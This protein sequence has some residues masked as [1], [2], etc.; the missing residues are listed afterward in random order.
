MS[1]IRCS[2]PPPRNTVSRRHALPRMTAMARGSSL[3]SRTVYARAP[4]RP[5]RPDL[6]RGGQARRVV[7][8]LRGDARI[9][10]VFER[11]GTVVRDARPHPQIDS[12][13]IYDYLY[14]HVIP[15]PRTAFEN[16]R[17]LPPAGFLE[18]VQSRDEI[19]RYWQPKFERERGS[20]RFAAEKAKFVRVLS[21]PC[22]RS[23]RT[24]AQSVAS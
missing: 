5:R 18:R 19:G 20:I 2:R 10:D 8:L 11:A 14:F 15:S 16:V 9:A 17:R 22:A 24:R 3:R 13:A 4:A 7:D 23:S 1:T 12:Q 6:A 21:P